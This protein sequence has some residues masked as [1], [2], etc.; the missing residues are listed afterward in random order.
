MSEQD[1][2]TKMNMI[3]LMIILS[4]LIF[5]YIALNILANKWLNVVG[6]DGN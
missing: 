5:A 2:S 4:S 3:L 6:G 1:V